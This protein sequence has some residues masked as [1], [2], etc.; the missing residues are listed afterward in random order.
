MWNFVKLV[1][2]SKLVEDFEG[3]RMNRVAA[4]FAVEVL[5]H[6]QQRDRNAPASEQQRQHRARRTAADNAARGFL[7]VS[8]LFVRG[9]SGNSGRSG[10]G[11]FH[12]GPGKLAL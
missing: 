3:R 1:R 4:E 2:Q 10:H 11:A 6:F 9:A 8:K 5:V 12:L 7:N